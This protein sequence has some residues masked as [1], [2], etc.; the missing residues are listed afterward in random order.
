M[1]TQLGINL[2]W[3]EHWKYKNWNI[4]QRTSVAK[5]NVID[6]LQPRDTIDIT[7]VFLSLI[8]LT[9]WYRTKISYWYPMFTQLNIENLV[10]FANMITCNSNNVFLKNCLFLSLF[11]SLLCCHFFYKR[12]LI[13][14]STSSH[15]WS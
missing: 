1:H 10:R 6:I 7:T 15:W 12:Y 9:L 8:T 4:E 2:R 13:S 14:A 5:R 3:N 11:L